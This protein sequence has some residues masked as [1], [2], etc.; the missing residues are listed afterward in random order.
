[1]SKE[2]V[3]LLDFYG[4]P[5]AMRAKIA[6]AEKGVEFE[7]R[8][9]DL[10]G[11]KSE[12]LLKSNPVYKKVPVL[13]HNGNPVSESLNILQYIEEAFPSPPLLP[14]CAHARA[15]ERFWADFVD[16]MLFEAGNKVWKSK[17]EA[18]E[19]AKAEFIEAVKALE[20]VLGEKDYFGGD[21][22]GFLD[23]A[24]IPFTSWFLAS[25]KFGGFKVEEECPTFMAWAKRCG[26]RESVAMA[27]PDPVKV[28]ELVCM[29]RKMHGIE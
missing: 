10:F 16:K 28:Y 6:L 25:E 8:H 19:A 22:F 4:S 12:L 27:L 5:F 15:T 7:A 17:G 21:V 1:M 24:T 14:K 23:I 20:G 9:E 3:I 13:L 26:E 18:V 11:G 2:E 29:L